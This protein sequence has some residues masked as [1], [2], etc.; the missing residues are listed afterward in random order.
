MIEAYFI[1]GSILLMLSLVV[2]GINLSIM[3]DSRTKGRP[4][5][6]HE[7]RT[8]GLAAAG[9]VAAVAW[10]VTLVLVLPGIAIY[11]LYK[12]TKGNE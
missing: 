8:I 7:W 1:V 3:L 4:L 12:S 9:P 2:G 6:D 11:A 10:P 5:R